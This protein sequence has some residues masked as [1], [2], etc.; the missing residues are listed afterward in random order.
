MPYALAD[1][2]FAAKLNSVSISFQRQIMGKSK[3]DGRKGEVGSEEGRKQVGSPATRSRLSSMAAGGSTTQAEVHPTP[4]KQH[5]KRDSS[6]KGEVADSDRSSVASSS[7]SKTFDVA[8]FV[9]EAVRRI[10]AGEKAVVIL[11][12]MPR[13]NK[14]W[15]EARVRACAKELNI[16]LRTIHLQAMGLRDG[17]LTAEQDEAERRAA[18]ARK[19]TPPA[20]ASTS[21]AEALPPTGE[22]TATQEETVQA[23]SLGM[24]KVVDE[25]VLAESSKKT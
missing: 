10:D 18:A 19:A 9:Q 12:D 3:K 24:T 11:Q 13:A 23:E 16:K 5:K 1:D 25:E 2:W 4:K 17:A 14:K 7:T 20:S 21:R 15:T 6:K 8:Y 22:V